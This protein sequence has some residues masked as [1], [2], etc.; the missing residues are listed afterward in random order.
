MNTLYE[1]LGL[2]HAINA[3]GKMTALGGSRL[4]DRVIAAM[5]RPP[6]AMW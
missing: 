1:D 3:S 4:D 5:G 2:T 6:A